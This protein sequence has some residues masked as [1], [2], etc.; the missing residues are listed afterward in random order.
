MP[1]SVTSMRFLSRSAWTDRRV[2]RVTCHRHEPH[3]LLREI[4]SRRHLKLGRVKSEEHVRYVQSRCSI[5][6]QSFAVGCVKCEDHGLHVFTYDI[7]QPQTLR[8]FLGAFNGNQSW[9]V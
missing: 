1:E 7:V 9:Y 4:V 3:V 2:G 8:G 5:Q 6:R